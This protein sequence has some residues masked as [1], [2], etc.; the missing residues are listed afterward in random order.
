MSDSAVAGFRASAATLAN[1]ELHATELYRL[2][3]LLTGD[4]A[5]SLDVTLEAIEDGD[6]SFFSHWMLA[7]SKRVIIAKALVAVRFDLAESAKRT[8][9]IRP[10]KRRLAPAGWTLPQAADTAAL[11][12]ALLAIDVF[13]RCALLLSV[14]ERV[15][16]ADAAILLDST[17]QAVEHARNLALRELTVNL[18]PPQ[19]RTSNAAGFSVIRGEMQ[20]A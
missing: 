18:A 7:W 17:P 1:P 12:G 5:T 15:P 13:P 16:L 11:D 20:H 14:F 6:G 4:G 19:R 9:G 10:E 3:Y 8:A 2:A